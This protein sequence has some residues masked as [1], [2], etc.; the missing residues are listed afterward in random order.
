MRNKTNDHRSYLLHIFAL[1]SMAVAQPL[2]DTIARNAEFLVAQKIEL[3][4]L[5]LFVVSLCVLIPVLLALPGQILKFRFPKLGAGFSMASI[6]LLVGILSILLLKDSLPVPDIALLLIAGISGLGF[7]FLYTRTPQLRMFCSYLSP[8]V[9]LV[10]VLFLMNPGVARIM[11]GS[12]EDFRIVE[13]GDKVPVIMLVLDELPLISLLEDELQVD[14]VR[15]PNFSRLSLGSH[16]FRN[17]T[18]P[19]A[20]TTQAVPA[21]LSGTTDSSALPILA[22]YPQNLFTM[23]EPSHTQNVSEIVTALCPDRICNPDEISTDIDIALTDFFSDLAIIYLHLVSPPEMSNSLPAINQSWSNFGDG[24]IGTSA[25][26][27][28]TAT[29]DLTEARRS[30]HEKYLKYIESIDGDIETPFYFYHALLPHMPWDFLP[31]GK[32]YTLTGSTPLGMVPG[33]DTWGDNAV[34][35]NQGYQ[36]HLLQLGFVDELLGLLIEKLETEDLYE[37]S[38]VIVVADHGA[39]FWPNAQRR[40]FSNDGQ[41]LDIRGVPMFIKLPHQSEGST[42]HEPASTLDIV[43]TLAGILGIPLSLDVDGKDLFINGMNGGQAP[44]AYSNNISLQ[45]KLDLFGSGDNAGLYAFGPYPQLLNRQ[46]SARST[47]DSELTGFEIDQQNYLNN[48]DLSSNMIPAWLTGRVTGDGSDLTGIDLLVTVNGISVASTTSYPSEDDHR[49]S[50]LIPESSLSNGYNEVNLYQIYSSASNQA[51]LEQIENLGQGQ[52]AYSTLS[53]QEN[54]QILDQSGNVLDF[55]PGVIRGGVESS[56]INGGHLQLSGWAVDSQ[57]PRPVDYLI[58]D[59]DGEL[60]YSGT[61]GSPRMDIVELFDTPEVERSGFSFSVLEP[62]LARPAAVAMR[63][64]GVSDGTASIFSSFNYIG[65]QVTELIASPTDSLFQFASDSTS[66]IDA[67]GRAL[68]IRSGQT[69]GNIDS[70]II[71]DG[72]AVINGW[73]ADRELNSVAD[74]FLL[75]IGQ[76]LIPLGTINTPRSDVV[77]SLESQDLLDSGFSFRIVESVFQSDAASTINLIAVIGSEAIQVA[78]AAPLSQYLP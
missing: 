67:D 58:L 5:F 76:Q 43:P 4:E 24:E 18:S 56:L 77:A 37:E 31:S 51:N 66:I 29:V 23:L 52:F 40:G 38:I 8:V 41:L 36:R 72:V 13:S 17:A 22:D 26:L 35:V 20:V 14:P 1:S 47:A 62:A 32:V 45:N 27:Q 19:V 78:S 46:I 28:P 59:A 64:I 42:H 3:N 69:T 34:L 2:L 60:S 57:S 50:V 33:E 10:P 11:N 15:F 65:T 61:P 73:A 70:F 49:F 25:S 74:Y 48:V 75:Q 39:N 68:A 53:T 55:I 30:R 16:W 44:S 7:I 71:R 6:G 54:L 21:V 63:V 9:L 12:G